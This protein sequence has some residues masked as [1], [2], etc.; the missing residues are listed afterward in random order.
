MLVACTYNQNELLLSVS[1]SDTNAF[2]LLFQQY[3]DKV[4]CVAC[5]VTQSPFLAEEAVQEIFTKLWKRR[6]ELSEVQQFDAWLNIIIRNHLFSVLKQE[7]ARRTRE[8][9][10]ADQ[11][12]GYHLPADH[13]VLLSETEELLER[14]LYTLPPQQNKVYK[15]IKKQGLK[16][17]EVASRLNLSPETVKAHFSKAVKTIR[18]YY[19]SHM[20]QTILLPI[21]IFLENIF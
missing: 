7:A 21:T 1:R 3:K 18:A 5:K 6:I 16:R 8:L 4:Y 12:P 19:L 9:V 17:E 15:L 10:F 13:K 11:Q 14:A 20:H 2:T